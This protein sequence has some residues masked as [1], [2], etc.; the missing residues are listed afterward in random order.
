ME[1]E[2]LIN[3]VFNLCETYYRN[4]LG[5]VYD[6]GEHEEEDRQRLPNFTEVWELKYTILQVTHKQ[7]RQIFIINIKINIFNENFVMG[8]F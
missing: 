7:G 2:W 4:G 3:L 1:L 5:S 6:A 8:S